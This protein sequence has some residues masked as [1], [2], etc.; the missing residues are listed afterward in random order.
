MQRAFQSKFADFEDRVSHRGK[1]KPKGLRDLAEE[2]LES[3]GAFRAI[4]NAGTVPSPNAPVYIR[5]DDPLG[6]VA[7]SPFSARM[8]FPGILSLGPQSFTNVEFV[9]SITDDEVSGYNRWT[10]EP[11]GSIFL[12]DVLSEEQIIDRCRNWNERADLQ[13]TWGRFSAWQNPPL[14]AQPRDI[15]V[16]PFPG[17]GINRPHDRLN[18]RINIYDAHNNEAVQVSLVDSQRH[19]LRTVRAYH[20]AIR[21]GRHLRDA[22]VAA[23]VSGY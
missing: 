16:D 18:S 5:N 13:L 9:R 19:I 7:T 22:N 23:Y 15:G 4:R 6:F 1:K 14:E 10:G 3:N 2:F 11:L 12:G 21:V 17:I 20:D 8:A